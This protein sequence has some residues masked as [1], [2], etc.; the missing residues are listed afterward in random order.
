MPKPTIST[1]RI[2][3]DKAKA[4]VVLYVAIAS[5]VTVFSL[6]SAKAL[7][8]K[9]SFGSRVVAEKENT[10]K[11]L[12]SNNEAATELATTYQTFNNTPDNLLGGNPEGSGDKDGDNAKIILDALPSQYDFPALTSSIEKMI[13][14]NGGS[15][16]SISGSDD[17][18]AQSIASDSSRP[19]EIP[20]QID[21]KSSP[22]GIQNILSTF[23]KSIRPMTVTKLTLTVEGE[24][25]LR[26][27]IFAKSYYQPK[28]IL[29]IKTKEV[30]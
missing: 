15:L 26:A 24:S 10:L 5:F 30:R 3:I 4:N 7:L 8:S 6:V 25:S 17:E 11:V 1:K 18:I 22:N 29:E 9:R 20:F 28:K 27:S 23:D 14:S 19:V 13:K 21:A 16:E 12:K 2:K